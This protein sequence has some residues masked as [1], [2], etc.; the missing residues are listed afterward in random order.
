MIPDLQ[1][2][3]YHRQIALLI[4]AQHQPNFWI[5]LVR[6]LHNLI[7]FDNWVAV[8][9]SDRK[10]PLV[11]I[12]NPTA[13]GSVDL[14]FQDYVNGLYLLDPFYVA[15]SDKPHSGLFLL[16]EVAPENFAQTDY[17]RLYF[18]LN[19]VADEVQFNCA[20]EDGQ[21]L[22][23]SLGRA[24][25]FTQTEIA[26]LNLVA[27]WVIALMQKRYQYEQQNEQVKENGNLISQ[28]QETVRA[29]V[30]AIRAKLT[31]REIE[32]S[33]LVLSGYSGKNIADKLKI[34]VETVKAHKKHIYSKL[35]IN[36]QHELF[37]IF[38]QAHADSS[39]NNSQSS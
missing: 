13:D 17:Y 14:L 23:L 8:L 33:Q 28:P 16:D 36:S 24:T 5:L 27:P 35:N 15:R 19:I 22:S 4:D 2:H 25:K 26:F 10:K 38:Y 6:T 39:I 34:S 21:T 1:E 3:S 9:F 29:E 32:I 18:Q 12:E 7:E 37:S 30:L 31:E 11:L 20:L